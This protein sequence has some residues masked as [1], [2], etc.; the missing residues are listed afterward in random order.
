[1]SYI[2]INGR[3]NFSEKYVSEEEQAKWL[4]LFKLAGCED[5]NGVTFP[6][7]YIIAKILR[8]DPGEPRSYDADLGYIDTNLVD[9]EGGHYYLPTFCVTPAGSEGAPRVDIHY[10]QP[11]RTD[12]YTASRDH[13]PSCDISGSLRHTDSDAMPYIRLWWRMLHV[14]ASIEHS[15]L[16]VSWWDY[17]NDR[18]IRELLPVPAEFTVEDDLVAWWLFYTATEEYN[19][20]R[21]KYKQPKGNPYA[22]TE[23]KEEAWISKCFSR[24]YNMIWVKANGDPFTPGWVKPADWPDLTFEALKQEILK[25][26]ADEKSE[27]TTEP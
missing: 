23:N 6:S 16:C 8:L 17:D 10:P 11:N 4:E 3:F 14:V 1:M 5:A 26:R 9:A 24:Y 13:S 7:E 19:A 2:H 15:C 20:Y 25:R 21:D 12:G 22:S 27:G 18:P